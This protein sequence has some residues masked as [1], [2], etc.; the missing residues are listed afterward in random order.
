M[1]QT[2][3]RQ[4]ADLFDRAHSAMTKE[5]KQADLH[6]RAH[7]PSQKA[8]KSADLLDRAPNKS[9]V[10]VVQAVVVARGTPRK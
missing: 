3:N 5:R 6:D 1:K 9:N 7:M 2:I 4:E 8:N 10:V